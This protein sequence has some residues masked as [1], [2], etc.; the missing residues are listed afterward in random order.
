MID[1]YN[2]NKQKLFGVL[3]MFKSYKEV[4]RTKRLRTTGSETE[5][6]LGP[7]QGVRDK[8]V[9]GDLGNLVDARSRY[10]FRSTAGQSHCHLLAC[11]LV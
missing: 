5:F 4:L 3:K 10:S 2:P 9:Q 11:L 7:W 6:E 1:R 8:V